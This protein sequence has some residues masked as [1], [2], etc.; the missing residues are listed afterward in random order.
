MLIKI[1]SHPQNLSMIKSQIGY[2]LASGFFG[3]VRRFGPRPAGP[4][5]LANA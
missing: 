5:G 3:L 1:R 4:L 2:W